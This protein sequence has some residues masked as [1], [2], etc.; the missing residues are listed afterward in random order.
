VAT[1]AR[2]VLGCYRYIELNPVSA[3]I[4]NHPARYTW[5]SYRANALGHD[6]RLIRPHAEFLALGLDS[7][8][9]RNA[10][11]ALF[12]QSLDPSLVEAIRASTRG[13]YPMGSDPS[14]K[15]GV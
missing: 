5:S 15:R 4:V 14:G 6:D 9:Q 1:T 11:A 8:A 2:Y 12:E 13:G 7:V 10:Y 3:G